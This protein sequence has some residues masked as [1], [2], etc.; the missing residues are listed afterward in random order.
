MEVNIVDAICGSGKTSAAINMMNQEGFGEKRY[1]YITPYLN[2]VERVK[3]ACA[4]KHFVEPKAKGSKLADLKRLVLRG[5]NIVSTHA[6]FSMFDQELIELCRNK[7]YILVMDEVANVVERMEIGPK[8]TKFLLSQTTLEDS[9]L[10]VW[11]D[12]DYHEGLYEKYKRLVDLKAIYCYSGTILIWNFPV[13][14]FKAFNESY[15]LTYMFDSQMQKYYYDMHGIEYNYLGVAGDS[16][17]TYH[18]TKERNNFNFKYGPLIHIYYNEKMNT[19]GN[20][21]YDLSKNWYNRVCKP[22]ASVEDKKKAFEHQK[23]CI[24]NYFRNITKTPSNLNMW[25]TFKDYRSALSGPGYAKGFVSCNARGT[26]EYR[27]RKALAYMVN[28]FQDPCV[29]NF[30]IKHN[31]TVD[32]DGYALSELIQWLFRSALRDKQEIDVYIPSLRTR[33]LLE[34][35]CKEN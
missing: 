33:D 17:D 16:L 11:N 22:T 8:D 2:E 30:F 3:K 29:V 32:Q 28:R 18:F 14:C 26:N 35:W 20:E 31:I 21:A 6:L 12:P 4:S 27:D 34:N 10:L 15:I 1:L 19:V 5:A 13:E 24:Y 23:N 25:T 9:G 7:G